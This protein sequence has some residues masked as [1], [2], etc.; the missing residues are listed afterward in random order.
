MA[1]GGEMDNSY[2][3]R[4]YDGNSR[5]GGNVEVTGQVNTASMSVDALSIGG[6][7]SVRSDGPSPLRIGFTSRYVDVVI[8]GGATLEYIVNIPDFTGDN[9]DIRVSVSQFAPAGGGDQFAFERT[10]ISITS[11]NATN[12]TV[13]MRLHNSAGGQLYLKGTVYLMAVAKN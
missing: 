10:I 12:G 4:V 8:P 11:V 13:R 9:D 5:F 2:R 7:G 1:I 3:L 6:K